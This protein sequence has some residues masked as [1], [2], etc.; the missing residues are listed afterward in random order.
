MPIEKMTKQAEQR[1]IRNTEDVIELVNNGLDPTEAVIKVASAADLSPTLTQRVLEAYNQSRTLYELS[2]KK[3]SARLDSFPLANPNAVRSRLFPDTTPSK[4]HTKNASVA[5]QAYSGST[6]N[7]IQKA[8]K[9]EGLKPS[10]EKS[11]AE[12][13]SAA[14]L[15]AMAVTNSKKKAKKHAEEKEAYDLNNEVVAAKEAMSKL[16]NELGEKVGSALLH[17]D[18]KFHE[19][20]IA[21][22]RKYGNDIDPIIKLAFVTS[23]LEKFGHRRA[24]PHEVDISSYTLSDFH[25]PAHGSIENVINAATNF[26]KKAQ[27]L[28]QAKLESGEEKRSFLDMTTG[29][30]KGVHKAVGNLKDT[31]D[32]M[33]RAELDK[34]VGGLQDPKFRDHLNQ[35]KVQAML[36]DLMSNDDVISSYDP[37]KVVDLFNQ[38]YDV[39]PEAASKPA[40][41]RDLLRRGL[42]NGGIEALEVGQ[43]GAINKDLKPGSKDYQ[44]SRKSQLENLSAEPNAEEN[45]NQKSLEAPQ[46]TPVENVADGISPAMDKLKTGAGEA[47]KLVTN[48]F[49][50]GRTAV[51]NTFGSVEAEKPKVEKPKNDK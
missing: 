4:L 14:A 36:H 8:A 15:G 42:V 51:N 9:W 22:K 6:E 23:K 33:Y 27:Q 16:A 30:I 19:V 3:G 17:S 11:A 10:M 2:E 29:A 34:A 31:G 18:V 26:H 37:D 46:K 5:L 38:L 43:L 44:Y 7:Y 50:K 21:L 40:I 28:K 25:S 32:T 47:S 20:E 13:M 41:M 1:L 39:A 12:G 49:S 35:I 48:L 45:K 24:Q